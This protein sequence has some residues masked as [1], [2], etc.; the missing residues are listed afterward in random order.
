VQRIAYQQGG[1][2]DDI[3]NPLL[4]ASAVVTDDILLENING[5]RHLKKELIRK[6]MASLG[7]RADTHDPI[8]DK[9]LGYIFRESPVINRLK[10]TDF[11][12][13]QI[14]I[15]EDEWDEE[16]TPELARWFIYQFCED[17]LPQTSPIFLFFFSIIYTDRDPEILEAVAKEVKNGAVL[18]ALPELNLVNRKDVSRWFRKYKLIEQNVRRRKALLNKYFE[19]HFSEREELDMDTVQNELERIINDFNAGKLGN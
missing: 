9:N 18:Q 1:Q 17:L 13:I 8:L 3:D 14:S 16:E 5:L 11:V 10:A 6:L 2:L 12:S 19:K 15:Y 4:E 7:L